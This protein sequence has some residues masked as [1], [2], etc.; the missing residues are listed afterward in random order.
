MI[1][2]PSP[3]RPRGRPSKGVDKYQQVCLYLPPEMVVAL[4]RLMDWQAQHTGH[5]VTRTE[6]I[7]E[8]IQKHLATA[9]PPQG[10]PQKPARRSKKP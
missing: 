1:T 8:A 10:G 3:S 5:H 7:R 2:H 9:L 4:D 6:V